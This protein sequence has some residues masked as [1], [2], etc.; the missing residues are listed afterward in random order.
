M[1]KMIFIFQ[2]SVQTPFDIEA[3]PTVTEADVSN[4]LIVPVAL[5][6]YEDRGNN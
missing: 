5:L 3:F 6:G 1:H 4:A 2:I